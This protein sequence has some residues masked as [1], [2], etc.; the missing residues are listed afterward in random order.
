VSQ[1]GLNAVR[2]AVDEVKSVITTLT[3]EEWAMPSGCVGWSVKD[4]VAHM[5]SNYKEIVSPSPPPDEPINL[6]AERMMDLLVEPRKHWSNTEIRDEYLAYCDGALAALAALQDEPMASTM[7]PLADLGTY[8]LHQYADA[9][10]FD[11]YCHLRVDLLAPSGPIRRNV[12]EADAAR[13]GPA[14]GW[15][16]AGIPQMQP[17]LEQSLTAPISLV[18]T[19]PGGGTWR[20]AA[21]GEG[22]AITVTEG[23]AGDEAAE[24]SSNGHSFVIWG[25]AREPWREHCS[26][27]GDT[28]VAETFF[29]ALNIV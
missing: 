19:G 11:H 24:V 25:T 2:L 13:I 7:V 10:A 1:A 26:V 17:G 5:S 27:T 4:L 12:P 21:D 14:V 15:M 28:A 29:D 9:F 3:D 16:L 6:P 22:G 18:L 8:S 20:L 23:V